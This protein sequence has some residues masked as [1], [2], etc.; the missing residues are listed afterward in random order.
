[1]M[2]ATPPMF[3][4]RIAINSKDEEEYEEEEVAMLANGSVKKPMI[5]FDHKNIHNPL[6]FTENQKYREINCHDP[7]FEHVT[8]A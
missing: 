8:G 4:P 3:N 7:K 5:S 6:D 1:M 2:T